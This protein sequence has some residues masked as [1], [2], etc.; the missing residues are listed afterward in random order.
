VNLAQRDWKAGQPAYCTDHAVLADNDPFMVGQAG[1]DF[2][3]W[4]HDLPDEKLIHWPWQAVN[5]LAGP[6]VPGRLTYIAAFPGGGKTTFLTH[7][8]YYWLA[9]GRSVL[10]LPLEAD[11][12]EVYTR[13]ACLELG[14]SADEALSF[15]L[16]KRADEGDER[17]AQQWADLKA[18]YTA[19]R[20]RH[21]LLRSEE[22]TSELQS[23]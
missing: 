23:L 7:C 3:E 19:M 13:L 18:M 9:S 5:D 4:L 22:H 16:R 15:R 17:A 6:L 2:A 8:L 14:V 12:G 11:P 20:F 10:Y 1:L 21:D